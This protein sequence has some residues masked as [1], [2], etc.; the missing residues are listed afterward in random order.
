M[1][2]DF[3]GT[4]IVMMGC[5]GLSSVNATARA[6]LLR[7]AESFVS[8]DDLISWGHSDAATERLLDLMLIEGLDTADAVAQTAAE[9]GPDPYFGA[10]LRVLTD[11]S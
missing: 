9:L 11:G 2:G 8:W 7:G 5:N 3:D 1:R 6:F 4:T 10:E